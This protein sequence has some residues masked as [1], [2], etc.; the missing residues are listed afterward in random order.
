MREEE[1]ENGGDARAN[2][3]APPAAGEGYV[4]ISYSSKNRA[5]A[6]SVCAALEKGGHRCWIAPRD[7]LPGMDWSES[8]IEALGASRVMVLVLSS[9]ANTSVQIKREAELAV[10]ANVPIIPFRVEDVPPSNALKYFLSTTHWL[11]AFTPP[12]GRHLQP[13][14]DAVSSIKSRQ[15]GG[16][17]QTRPVASPAKPKSRAAAY[18]V[19]AIILAA[20]AAG[21]AYLSWGNR[22]QPAVTPPA[23]PARQESAQTR[24]LN[25]WVE[26]QKYR[27]GKPDKEPFR[28]AGELVFQAG[29]HVWLNFSSPQAGHLYL[30]NEGPEPRDGL[31]QY[32][33]L[34]PTP[35]ANNNSSALAAGQELRVPGA[36]GFVIDD[37]R[38]TEKVWLVW[39]A[40]RVDELEAIAKE[41]VTPERRGVV[42]KPEQIR[43]VQSFIAARSNPAPQES[44][45]EARKLTAVSGPGDVIVSLRKLEHY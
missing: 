25:Y 28:L 40:R 26:V 32:N 33:V 37:E 41:V 20:A 8:I 43:S 27:D 21:A 18:A 23:G 15:A 29:D 42:G 34:F 38:G 2:T 36:R 3:P 19:G 10:N 11:D 24:T 12:L 13:L 5:A 1:R 31:P 16:A 14:V 4:F 44:K 35:T 39:S 22:R 45:D 30:V 9:H 17:A 7:I 6:D